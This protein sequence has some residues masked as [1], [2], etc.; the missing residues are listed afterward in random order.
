MCVGPPSSPAGTVRVSNITSD[1]CQV[2]WQAPD[3]DGGA[4][5]TSYVIEIRE[6]TRSVWRRVGIVNATTTTYK[7]CIIFYYALNVYLKL[8]HQSSVGLYRVCGRRR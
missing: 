2:R 5:V 6:S 4:P 8:H 7:V 3:D 1:S